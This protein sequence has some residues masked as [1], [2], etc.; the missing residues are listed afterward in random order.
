[1]KTK[2]TARLAALVLFIAPMIALADWFASTDLYYA[3]GMYG[4]DLDFL[5]D[6]ESCE[7]YVWVECFNW[8]GGGGVGERWYYSTGG[9][10]H[11]KSY[12]DSGYNWAY[13]GTSFSWNDEITYQSID[14]WCSLIDAYGSIEAW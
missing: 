12:N 7:G 10:D 3:S 8:S 1:M 5:G 4:G 9:L 2:M 11:S 14:V 13:A 6:G